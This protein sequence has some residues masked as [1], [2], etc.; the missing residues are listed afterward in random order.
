VQLYNLRIGI[1]RGDVMWRK[2]SLVLLVLT[3]VS[4]VTIASDDL[5][6][7]SLPQ[8]DDISVLEDPLSLN[9][10]LSM[11]A[12]HTSELD[13]DYSDPCGVKCGLSNTGLFLLQMVVESKADLEYRH[14]LMNPN[15]E[16]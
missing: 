2:L 15:Y 5:F 10:K 6:L 16:P 3:A 8:S 12:E 4:K 14:Q 11:D 7:Y 1:I 9:S 13:L